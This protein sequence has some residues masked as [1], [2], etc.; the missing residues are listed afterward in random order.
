[1]ALYPNQ[2]RAFDRG[3]IGADHDYKIIISPHLDEDSAPP[4]SLNSLAGKSI[5][6]P[7]QIQYQTSRTPLE[8]HR[9]EVFK[10]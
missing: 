4:Y 5:K 8:W 10:H 3:L 9:I 1:M 2:H 7:S 6:L